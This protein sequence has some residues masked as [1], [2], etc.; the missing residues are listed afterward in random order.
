MAG[1]DDDLPQDQETELEEGVEEGEEA[2]VEEEPVEGEGEPPRRSRATERVLHFR[3]EARAERQR[4]DDL[5][6]QIYEL[7]REQTQ[8]SGQYDQQAEQERLNQMTADERVDYLLQRSRQEQQQFMAQQQFVTSDANDRANFR[9]FCEGVP[10]YQKLG[11]QVENELAMIRRTYGWNA[12]RQLVLAALLGLQTINAQS[13]VRQ[14]RDQGQKR[15]RSQ[16]TRPTSGGSD[17]RRGGERL[18]PN[19]PEARRKRLEGQ[20]F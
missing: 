18:D 5:Q 11:P 7:Q 2:E 1:E 20:T 3:E 17:V 14:Q 9:S 13:Q 6:R 4:A 16:S 10:E 12:P 15:I 8:R 19:S